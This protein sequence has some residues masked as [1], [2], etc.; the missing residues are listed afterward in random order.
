MKLTV[1][2]R[3]D[4]FIKKYPEPYQFKITLNWERKDGQHSKTYFPNNES[5]RG[6]YY[7]RNDEFY[8]YTGRDFIAQHY[9]YDEK[10]G[11]LELA[12]AIFDCHTPKKGENRRW[13]YGYRYFIPKDTRELYDVNGKQERYDYSLTT[14]DY[15][16]RTPDKFA[17]MFAKVSCCPHM[18]RREFMA[19]A[20]DNLQLKNCW[21]THITQDSNPWELEYWFRYVPKQKTTGKMQKLID[22]L[23]AKELELSDSLRERI[24]SKME[25]DRYTKK[26]A[27]FD[28]DHKVF[29]CFVESADDIFEDK[30]V[31]IA[32]KGK[33]AVATI[34]PQGEWVTN[35]SFTMRRF[36]F[37]IIN[38]IL[39]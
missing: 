30:R 36:N 9:R 39:F 37:Q 18:F 10:L 21:S 3:I 1:K 27:W 15:W 22:D 28:L 17:Q 38:T 34:N 24:K 2:Q 5:G 13:K 31:Y 33:Y 35:G 25:E 14:Y 23:S 16:V 4:R 6:R 11:L 7:W 32:G 20:G 8:T 26:Y 12:Y 29:R 19:F